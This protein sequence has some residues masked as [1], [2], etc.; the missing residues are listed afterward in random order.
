MNLYKNHSSKTRGIVSF[1][2]KVGCK[3]N[4]RQIEQLQS[5][6][7]VVQFVDLL[8]LYLEI[9]SQ[10]TALGPSFSNACQGRT[11]SLCCLS[12]KPHITLAST[13]TP[14]GAR[15]SLVEHSG[16]YCIR[17]NGQPLMHS[18][19]TASE[20]LLGTLG[21]ERHSAKE[22]KPKV[23]IGGLGLGFTLMSV[24]QATGPQSEVHVVELF[25]EIV[26]WNRTFIAKLNG[27]SLMDPRTVVIEE[28]VRA[29]IARSPET[30]D[31]MALDIDNN[32]TAMVKVENHELYKKL[33]IQ[34]IWNALKPG[35][36]AAI[37]F[38]APDVAIERLLRKAGFV[39]KAVPAKVR[40][41]SRREDYM[42][43]VADKPQ[44]A[45]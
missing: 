34:D 19:D 39:V 35:G 22:Q 11:D 31:A 23:L 16:S 43:Y 29:V 42:I 4:A 5:A 20:I 2:G 10:Q 13:T 6:G 9:G 26:E 27:E 37:W 8:N 15:M 24:L 12:M 3:G 32:T 41:S 33:G 40:A 45:K 21:C 30:Y 38:A 28:D 7:Y 17:V 14:N 25:P 36:R 1:Y 44:S 18:D